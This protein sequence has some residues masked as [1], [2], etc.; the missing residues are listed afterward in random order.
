[1]RVLL[2]A[3]Y[4]R[5]GAS[6]RIRTLQFIPWLAECGVSVS[7]SALM[8]DEFRAAAAL[9]R[10]PSTCRLGL[11]YFERILRRSEVSNFDL[12][13]IEK[14]AIPMVP[15]WAERLLYPMPIP[16]VVDYDDATFHLYGLNAY[17]AVRS[18]LGSKI[19]AV[20][21][22]SSAVV[23]G[24]AYNAEHARLA[25]AKQIAVIPSVVDLSRYQI[26]KENASCC[27]TIGWIG[28][29]STA[30]YLS[31][32][33]SLMKRD[34]LGMPFRVLLIGTGPTP[35]FSDVDVDVRNWSEDE[36]VEAIHSMDVGIMPL[37]L[38]PWELGKCAYKLVQY[39]ACSKPVVASDVGANR[40]VVEH[41]KTGFLVS[42]ERE[43]KWALQTLSSSPDLRRRM[44]A[45]GRERVE[46]LYSLQAVAPRLL[47]VFAQAA[48]IAGDVAMSPRRS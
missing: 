10:R 5:F 3:R 32:L 44:G 35:V 1:M 41:G 18:I 34:F 22:N 43:W 48:K 8:T 11:K 40:D 13:W 20:M 38:G 2:L 47:N 26:R 39:M 33:N 9:G 36:E 6:S 45:A 23:A 37:P 17:R 30:K 4:G 16:Y 24:N 27:F 25:G 42:S 7:V 12:L 19:D 31:G 28:S 46:R 15:G 29:P 14:E 21:R